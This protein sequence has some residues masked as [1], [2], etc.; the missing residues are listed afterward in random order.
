MGRRRGR[1]ELSGFAGMARRIVRAYGERFAEEGDE[2]ELAELFGLIGSVDDA[3]RAAIA[4][5]R[6]RGAEVSWARIGR[7]VG[8]TGEG[9]RKRWGGDALETRRTA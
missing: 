4:H 6:A 5:M 7:A 3:M 1:V 9:A 2:Q 8:M